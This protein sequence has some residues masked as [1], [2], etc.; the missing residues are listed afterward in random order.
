MSLR[1]WNDGIA[2][3]YG[4]S[5]FFAGWL[6]SQLTDALVHD[7]EFRQA[8]SV[9]GL[10]YPCNHPA[11]EVIDMGLKFWSSE[12]MHVCVCVGEGGGGGVSDRLV[13]MGVGQ[14]HTTSRAEPKTR[15]YTSIQ[16]VSMC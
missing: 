4:L 2:L 9:V 1:F 10:H 15:L 7:D 5:W 14:V 6:R 16:A 8:V 3:F 11:P 13:A 12:G